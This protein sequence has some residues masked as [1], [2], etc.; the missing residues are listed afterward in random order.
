MVSRRFQG[1]PHKIGEKLGI[2]K[3]VLKFPGFALGFA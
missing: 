3:M 2:M 1:M